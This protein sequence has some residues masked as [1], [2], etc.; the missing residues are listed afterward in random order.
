M[1]STGYVPRRHQEYLHASVRRFNVI[2]C[3]RR[4]GKT[5]WGINEIIDQAI[6]CK[7]KNPQYAYLAPTYGSAKRIAWD[8]VKIFTE[9]IPGVSYHEGELRCEF[10]RPQGDKVRIM[11]LGAEN[12]GSLRGIYLD[13]AILDEFSEMDPVAWTQVIRPALSDRFGWAHFIGT[14]KGANHFR[15]IYISA[16]KFMK[17]DGSQWFASLFK[18]SQTKIVAQNELEEARKTM[19]QDE[20]DQEFECS[21]SAAMAGA[22]YKEQ[23][24]EIDASGRIMRVPYDKAVPVVTGW[25]LGI[26]DSTAVWFAQGVGRERHIIDYYEVSGKG[27]EDIVKDILAKPYLYGTHF[28][29]H[30]AGARELGT[31]VTREETMRRLGLRDVVVVPRLRVEEGI[32]AARLMLPLCYFDEE[33]TWAGVEGLRAYEREYN[34]KEGVFRSKPRHNW[35]SHPSDAFRTLSLGLGQRMRYDRMEDRDLPEFLETDYDIFGV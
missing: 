3:H 23:F 20:F 5:T 21:F 1:I 32:N 31:G 9:K 33:K 29:P 16:K 7:Q 2:V 14:P 10:P 12:P 25:D 26:D 13:G 27:L 4:F 6:R 8:M 18:A 34:T 35:A 15:D 11:L 24:R 17:E 22:Y 19:G 30:D 28:L